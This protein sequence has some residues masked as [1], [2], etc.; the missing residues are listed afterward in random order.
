MFSKKLDNPNFVARAAP[1]VVQ[2]QRE[3]LAAAEADRARLEAARER[4]AALG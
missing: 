1:E 4:L 2:E 3:K